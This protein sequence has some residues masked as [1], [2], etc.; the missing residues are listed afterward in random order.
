MSQNLI[1]TKRSY[2]TNTTH[3]LTESNY[4]SNNN[5]GY[6]APPPRR[7]NNVNNRLTEKIENIYRLLIDQINENKTFLGKEQYIL[8]NNSYENIKKNFE[9]KEYLKYITKKIKAGFLNGGEAGELAIY[10]SNT[11]LVLN[12]HLSQTVLLE[13]FVRMNNILT[14]FKIQF[15]NEKIIKQ[16]KN[17]EIIMKKILAKQQLMITNNNF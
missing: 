14:F 5:N 16:I 7:I 10:F 17:N 9:D 13:K 4:N 12:P 11:G 8:I 3:S 6:Y 15:D 2:N 1:K